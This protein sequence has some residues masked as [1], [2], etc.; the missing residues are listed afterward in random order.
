MTN[1]YRTKKFEALRDK[2]YAKLEKSGFAD[3]EQKDGHLKEW[4]SYNFSGSARS[5][6]SKELFASKEEY[7]RLAG[8]FLHS[9]TFKDERDR[10]IWEGHTHGKTLDEISAELKNKRKKATSRN[11][12][13]LTVRYLAKEML[14]NVTNHK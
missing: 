11:A 4:H 1:P 2:W 6:Y 3:A 8:A 14:K 12:V 9:H 10:I 7:Y 13:H 5:R